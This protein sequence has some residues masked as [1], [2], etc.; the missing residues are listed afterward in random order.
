MA[1]GEGYWWYIEFLG[2]H[3]SE[4]SMAALADLS[5][6]IGSEEY[7]SDGKIGMKA[8][9]RS[10]HDLDFWVARIEKLLGLFP[11]I[12]IADTGKIKK[13]KWNTEWKEAFPPLPVGDSFIVMAPWHRGKDLAG[14]IPLY[15]YPGSA[16]GT[17]YHESTQIALSLLEKYIR[18]GDDV[19]DIGT[20][21]AI[22][23][24]A[25][26]KKGAGHVFSRDIDP[27]V[28][29]E[30]ARNLAQNGI[31]E[32]Y[33]TFDTGNLL[34]GFGHRVDMLVANILIGPL[35]A[36]VPDLQSVLKSGG[37]AVFSGMVLK[38][39]ES[40]VKLLESCGFSVADEKTSND[41]W[42]VV[43]EKS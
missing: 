25:A 26:V 23:T 37:K 27:A 19:A 38:E 12:S 2:C 1:T 17:G 22:L 6:S 32:G 41:W 29:D 34:Q 33:V 16:F 31:P 11:G 3:V 9:Y 5:G 40:F 8:Y 43:V 7:D 4:E 35:T 21:S 20:G 18:I 15:I 28:A 24:I 13:Q 36:L 42:G 14:R 10:V 39:K 30:V